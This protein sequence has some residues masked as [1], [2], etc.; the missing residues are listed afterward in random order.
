M[1]LNSYVT[2]ASARWSVVCKAV[3]GLVHPQL[4]QTG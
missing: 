4:L 1:H 2:A 3:L